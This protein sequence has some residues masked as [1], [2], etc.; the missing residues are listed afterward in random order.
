[1][2]PTELVLYVCSECG[3]RGLTHPG[4][5]KKPRARTKYCNGR[6]WAQ[7]Y[8]LP[9]FGERCATLAEAMAE[10]ESWTDVPH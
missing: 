1:M 2:F 5:H 10:T 6:I 7:Q 3:K 8:V 4:Q 9:V